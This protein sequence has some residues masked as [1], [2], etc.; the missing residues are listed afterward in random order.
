MG[1]VWL[2]QTP[3]LRRLAFGLAALVTVLMLALSWTPSVLSR[4]ETLSLD[5]R[6][7]LRGERPASGRVVLVAIDERSLY[8]IAVWPWPRELEAQL[9]QKIRADGAAV[10]GLDII[11]SEPGPTDPPLVRSVAAAGNVVLGYP[12]IVPDSRLA[13]G[14]LPGP[15]AFK[16][17]SH[18]VTVK[19]AGSP[20][21]LQPHQAAAVAA[22]LQQLAEY[23]TGMGHVYSIPDW[24]GVTRYEYL[25][26]QYDGQ[27]Y[28]SFALEV[29]RA[30]LHVPRE[31]MILNIGEGI[32]LGTRFIPTDQKSRL[33]INYLGRERSFPYISATDVLH[34]RV[35]KHTFQDRIVLV[36]TAALGTYDQKISPFSNN[37]PGFEK[38]A[39]VVENLLEQQF[40]SKTLWSG[41][42]DA[43]VIIKF[44]LG[45]GYVLPRQ[46]ALP[47]AGLAV[48]LLIV[49]A[50]L[51][52]YLFVSLG[53][54]IEGVIPL[55]TVILTFLVIVVLRFMTEER[56]SRE[57]ARGYGVGF[58]GAPWGGDK[59]PY[60]L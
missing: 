59:Y 7:K 21:E 52:V 28:P 14:E 37:Y 55:L 57:G 49:Y 30:Y 54:C 18:F 26:L 35:P 39:T 43:A 46:S 6:F 11:Y 53:V 3:K 19:G 5:L 44:G 17:R 50:V 1:Q 10:I 23:A 42:L 41:P 51:A 56:Q 33:L 2:G 47:G 32:Q 48:V 45:L 16:N 58:G 8:E 24:D 31:H 40:L 25:A 36:G 34:N 9:V 29:T 60:E 13:H 38:N 12:F 15:T 22:P 27:Y 4:L 20:A